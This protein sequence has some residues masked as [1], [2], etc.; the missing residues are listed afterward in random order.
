MITHEEKMALRENLYKHGMAL[1]EK[2][3]KMFESGELTSAQMSF[4]GDIMK[5]IAKMDKS[6]SAAC[7]YDTERGASAD[8]TY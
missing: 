8:K 2:V 6:L 5:D 3:K 7:Y 4:A 1:M